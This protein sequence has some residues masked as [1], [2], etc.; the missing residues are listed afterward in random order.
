MSSHT[1]SLSEARRIALVAQG[2]DRPRP[3]GPVSARHVRAAIR[4][5]GLLQID[6]VNVLAPAHYLVLFSRL[7]PYKKTFLEDLIYREREFT[8]QWAHEASILPMETWPLLRHRMEGHRVR[9]YGF[10]SFMEEHPEYVQQVVEDVRARGPLSA[11]DFGASDWISRHIPDAWYGSVPRATLEAHFGRGLLAVADRRTNFSRAYDLAERVIPKKHFGRQVGREEAQR[12]LVRLAAR[13]HG[14][15]AASDLA[16]YYR[17]PVRD[18]RPRIAELLDSGELRRVQVEGWREPAFM[19]NE[20][21]LPGRISAATLLS[22][23]DP[24]IWY[25]PRTSR[26]FG[27][28]Y[29]IEIFVPKDKRRWGYYVLPFL[30]G[31]RLVA[32]VD[33]KAD[34]KER[35]LHVLAAY[36]EPK[37]QPASVADALAIE[38]RTLAAWL[39]L[40]SVA[41]A[42]HGNFAR[43][44][45]KAV[46]ARG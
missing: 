33:L 31:D 27:F 34:R 40:D 14:V 13:A 11:D 24:L 23:F 41:V 8:E 7:G 18:V 44:L 37:C 35:R 28:D 12:E 38:L 20:S 19:H 36:L 4:Q 29:R 22:P 5:L 25:R 32:R 30:Q 17:M 15:A 2:F 6:Y 39:S 42:P 46:L 21:R 16:D 9:P 26:L 43:A 3:G 45:A 10:E 1:L